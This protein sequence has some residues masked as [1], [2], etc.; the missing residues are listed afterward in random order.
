MARH[1]NIDWRLPE[2][3]AGRTL[4]TDFIDCALLM[5]IRDELRELNTLLNCP[6]FLAIPGKLE[7]IR[8]NTARKRPVKKKGKR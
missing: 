7:Q 8:R 6:N 2:L 4:S 5:D 1:K 3:A